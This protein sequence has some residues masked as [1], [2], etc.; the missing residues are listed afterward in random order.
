M[1]ATV[2]QATPVTKIEYARWRSGTPR[3]SD[4]SG[5][6]RCSIRT[7]NT[8]AA[9]RSVAAAASTR[10]RPRGSRML[11]ESTEIGYSSMNPI[12]VPV[13]PVR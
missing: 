10:P 2:A 12:R 1:R 6:G 5:A 7:A 4:N 9:Y 8:M 13:P 3:M 11:P